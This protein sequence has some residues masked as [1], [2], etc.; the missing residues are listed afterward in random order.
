MDRRILVF[1][2]LLAI[3]LWVTACNGNLD[4]AVEELNRSATQLAGGTAGDTSGVTDGASDGAQLPPGE[5]PVPEVTEPAVMT[6]DLPVTGDTL[7]HTWGQI[8]ALASGTNFEI[9]ATE[10]QVSD[11]VIERL[12]A[13]GWDANVHGGSV[14]I[15]G[16]QL[17]V[18]LALESESGD[19]GGGAVSFQPTLDAASSLRLN[20]QGG[21]FG[22]LRMPGNFTAAIGDAVYAALTGAPNAQTSSVT[23]TELTLDAGTVR[24]S[25]TVR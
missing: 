18:D 15:S 25:G 12:Q 2:A 14:T 16:G 9:T 6:Y 21:D 13:T 10:R 11:Y 19:F 1:S 23:L 7:A 8:Y 24:V 5:T 22:G 4:N 3:A 17:R 20:A